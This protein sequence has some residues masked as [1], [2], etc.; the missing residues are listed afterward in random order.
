MVDDGNCQF[1]ALSS[2]CFGTQRWHK[3]IRS[4]V[5]R[6]VEKNIYTNDNVIMP[7]TTAAAMTTKAVIVVYLLRPPPIP[8]T[9]KR[10]FPNIVTT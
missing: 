2:E 8:P 10:R 9:I 4:K 1:R 7:M 6:V 5:K 3:T